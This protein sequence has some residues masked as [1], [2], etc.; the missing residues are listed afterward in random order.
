MYHSFNYVTFVIASCSHRKSMK[1]TAKW[2]K[3]I[4]SDG[5][6]V[7]IQLLRS[8]C[9]TKYNLNA[10]LFIFIYLFYYFNDYFI[11][12]SKLV[13][14]EIFIQAGVLKIECGLLLANS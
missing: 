14:D 8:K 12:I 3:Q 2:H 13:T 1:R 6:D 9:M 10:I 5:R 11:D 4:V 7:Q